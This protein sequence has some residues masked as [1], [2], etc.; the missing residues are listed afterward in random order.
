[1]RAAASQGQYSASNTASSADNVT[2]QAMGLEAPSKP[3]PGILAARPGSECGARLAAI[4][5]P[6]AIT[7]DTSTMARC[8]SAVRFAPVVSGNHASQA[9]PLD[10]HGQP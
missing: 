9:D 3:L 6:L 7:S 4:S 10:H 2:P 5:T 8:I 1:M